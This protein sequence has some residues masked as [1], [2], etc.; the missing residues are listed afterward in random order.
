MKRIQLTPE[1]FQVYSVADDDFVEVCG[2]DGKIVG[3]IVSAK[4]Q[5][6]VAE[7]KRRSKLPGPRYSGE[8]VK[9]M[10]QTLEEKSQAEGVLSEERLREILAEIRRNREAS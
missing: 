2:T 9:Q 8:Q 5:E 7:C 3:R 4:T 1:Q 6:I 10:L